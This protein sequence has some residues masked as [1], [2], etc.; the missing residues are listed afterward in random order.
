MA[1]DVVNGQ[2]TITAMCNG[3]DASG[4]QTATIAVTAPILQACIGNIDGATAFSTTTSC[5]VGLQNKQMLSFLGGTLSINDKV[6]LKALDSNGSVTLS[7]GQTATV[8]NNNLPI[9]TT[10]SNL[11]NAVLVTL[12]GKLLNNKQGSVTDNNLAT[13]LLSA[14]GNVLQT[15]LNTLKGSLS[16]LQTF[17]NNLN[18]DVTTIAG[19]S[20]GSGVVSLLN[21]VGGLVNGLLTGVGNLL[22]SVIGGLLNLLFCNS[23]CQ[24]QNQ[25]SGNSSNS[26]VSNVLLALMGI[27]EKLLEPILNGLGGQ[28]AS[29][30]NNLLGIG[31]GQVDVT[32]IDL[33]CGGGDNVKLV[34]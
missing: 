16:S 12:L 31:L 24:V 28:I 33:K 32:L 27:L 34:F 18:S 10:V 15:T 30:L 7:K 25:L 23:H 17:I 19:G 3:R 13:A 20:L 22:N 1:I 8:G 21:S 6:V 4:N 9:G 11:T 14:D 26:A 29:L 2:G 5:E